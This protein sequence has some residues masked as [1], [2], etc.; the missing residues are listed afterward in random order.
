MNNEETVINIE[1]DP[2]I[3]IKYNP[4]LEKCF[5]APNPSIDKQTLNSKLLEHYTLKG[6]KENRIANK[7]QLNKVW[8]SEDDIDDAFDHEFYATEYP[9]TL[10]FYSYWSSV[11][12]RERLFN[13]YHKFGKTEGRYKN[14]QQKNIRKIDKLSIS[15]IVPFSSLKYFANHLECVALLVTDIEIEKGH[16]I[17]FINRLLNNTNKKESKRIDFKI[18][19]NKIRDNNSIDIGNLKE[20]F[21]SVE[22]VNLNLS[23][24][25]DLYIRDDSKLENTPSHG[26]KS[27][28]NVMFYRAMKICKQYNTTLLLETDCFF[29]TSWLQ[30]LKDFIN[31][32]NGF[33]ISGAIYDGAILTKAESEISTHIN[34]GVGLYATGNETFQLF[35]DKSELFL[36]EEIK[37]GSV[38]LAYD[39]SIKT[40]INHIMNTNIAKNEDILVA[41]FINRQYL[42][43]KIIGNFSTPKDTII[44]LEQISEAYNYYIIHKK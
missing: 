5:L 23:P 13:H 16:Y 36:I 33:W 17:E 8:I 37:N 1:F 11:S 20:L 6:Q 7:Q 26:R 15:E 38:G 25:D 9:D 14:K 40:Y 10:I 32:S 2:G 41:K 44:S 30:K 42:P 12:L 27:G 18:I 4:D 3:Y 22:I 31:H 24:E 19:I 34:G 21:R 29:R 43:N 35:I 28:P 39:V